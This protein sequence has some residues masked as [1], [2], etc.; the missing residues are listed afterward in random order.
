MALLIGDA[1]G[2]YVILRVFQTVDTIL[3]SLLGG[4]FSFNFNVSQTIKRGSKSVI[5]G[6]YNVLKNFAFV[7]AILHKEQ[8]KIEEAFDKVSLHL[9]RPVISTNDV[10]LGSQDQESPDCY[11]DYLSTSGWPASRG[12]PRPYAV[13]HYR[14]GRHLGNRTRGSLLRL[15]LPP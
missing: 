5:D 9:L 15:I 6:V 3:R 10:H 11:G 13:S 2:F 1:L 12:D 8:L 7:Q 14:G 4:I